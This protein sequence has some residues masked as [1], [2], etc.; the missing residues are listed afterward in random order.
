MN[1]GQYKLLVGK[2]VRIRSNSINHNYKTGCD[3]VLK[4]YRGNSIFRATDPK[5]PYFMGSDLYYQDFD[6]VDNI[7]GDLEEKGLKKK[8]NLANEIDKYGIEAVLELQEDQ[9]T[10]YISSTVRNI[11]EV[12]NGMCLGF[13]VD[14]EANAVYIFKES[15]EN[16]GLKIDEKGCIKS[17]A[18]VRDLV[19][20]VYS[21]TMTLDSRRIKNPEFEDNIFYKIVKYNPESKQSL[22]SLFKGTQVVVGTSGEMEEKKGIDFMQY[23]Q[24]TDNV[25]T[26]VRKVG[27]SKEKYPMYTPPAF[28]D[29]A[30]DVAVNFIP[31]E[32]VVELLKEEPEEEHKL[33]QK[34]GINVEF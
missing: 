5:E 25:K 16:S 17:F 24:N 29:A 11:L 4:N 14:Y 7:I 8:V 20:Y 31:K 2:T 22:D 13:A 28:Y 9:E 1:D 18:I 27:K 32:D 12:E 3:Y 6:I 33:N 15:E 30:N 23:F 21:K 19:N 10:V 26:S 34:Q